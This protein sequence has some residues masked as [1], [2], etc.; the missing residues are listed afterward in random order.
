M[1]DVMR[2]WVW[3]ALGME[4]GTG[5]AGIPLCNSAYERSYVA[6][7]G[8][9]DLASFGLPGLMANDKSVAPAAVGTRT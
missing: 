2:V 4:F 7:C 3:I 5:Y 9:M 1:G 8:L 6:A